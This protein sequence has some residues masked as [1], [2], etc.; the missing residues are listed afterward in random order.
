MKVSHATNE[1][2]VVLG[3]LQKTRASCALALLQRAKEA[4]VWSGVPSSQIVRQDVQ[5]LNE[6]A[7]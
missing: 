1:T 6:A 5:E 7:L 3:R 4:R 2:N